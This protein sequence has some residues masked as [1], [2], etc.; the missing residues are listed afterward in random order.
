[1]T[2]RWTPPR[3]TDEFAWPGVPYAARRSPERPDSCPL[4]LA[5]GGYLFRGMCPGEAH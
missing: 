4:R 1:M 2:V 5:F 3:R